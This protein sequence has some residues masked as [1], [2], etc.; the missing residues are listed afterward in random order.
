MSYAAALKAQSGAD[1]MKDMFLK[2]IVAGTVA[3]LG[4]K[5]LFSDIG[6]GSVRVFGI[7][8]PVPILLGGAVGVGSVISE[9]LRQKA[10]SSF[11]QGEAL[12]LALSGGL[13]AGAAMGTVALIDKVALG[14]VGYGRLAGLGVA[15]EILADQL[16]HRVLKCLW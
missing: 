5:F 12:S 6:N 7:D 13:N 15:N 14:Q 4:T 9:L 2:P 16:Y 8:V 1:D 10:F 3:G 11:Q